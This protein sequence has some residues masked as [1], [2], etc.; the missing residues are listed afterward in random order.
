MTDE[1]TNQPA[2]NQ[3]GGGYEELI[4]ACDLAL[5]WADA[6]ARWFDIS[7]APRDESLVMFYASRR[8]HPLI[9]RADDYW[10]G[11][12]WLA[13]ATHWRPLPPPPSNP[14]LPDPLE[15]LGEVLRRIKGA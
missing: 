10:A 15:R 12:Y 3:A 2:G 4:A 6:D 1:T 13:D 14:P 5:N 11:A 8:P 9:N 7:T